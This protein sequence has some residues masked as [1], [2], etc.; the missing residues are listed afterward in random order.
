MS[1]R[2]AKDLKASLKEAIA[3]EKAGL[4]AVALR[5]INNFDF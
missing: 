4:P 3:Y 2:F 5:E 1:S